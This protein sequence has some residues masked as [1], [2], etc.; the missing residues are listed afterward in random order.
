[1]ATKVPE[2]SEGRSPGS[3]ATPR[4]DDEAAT[5]R[6]GLAEASEEKGGKGETARRS[7]PGRLAKALENNRKPGN[8]VGRILLTLDGW[9]PLNLRGDLY[10]WGGS[11]LQWP[12]GYH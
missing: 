7:L 11:R 5:V 8:H 4:E 3:G 6:G 12:N 10:P 2:N 1:M 9:L